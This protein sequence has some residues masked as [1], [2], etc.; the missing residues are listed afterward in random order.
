MYYKDCAYLELTTADMTHIEDTLG[1]ISYDDYRDMLFNGFIPMI[2][3]IEESLFCGEKD[4]VSKIRLLLFVKET[5]S[6]RKDR[7]YWF[8]E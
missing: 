6:Q 8:I 3:H 4:K 7:Q 1:S 2:W 5:I